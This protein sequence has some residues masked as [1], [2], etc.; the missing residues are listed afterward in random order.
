[1]DRNYLME[2]SCSAAN[3]KLFFLCWFLKKKRSAPSSHLRVVL[4]GLQA[5]WQLLWLLLHWSR[6]QWP[7]GACTGLLQHD[8]WVHRSPHC[9]HLYSLRV[10]V[11]PELRAQSQVSHRSHGIDL[12]RWHSPETN[13][14]S[15]S[16]RFLPT[17]PDSSNFICVMSVYLW[18][19]MKIYCK[20][21]I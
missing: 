12:Q 1:M 16:I 4:R 5:D 8:R 18:R 13:H 15:H 6:W 14:Y 9:C 17:I 2:I 20:I 7:P 10:P 21:I 3:R 19:S 11:G